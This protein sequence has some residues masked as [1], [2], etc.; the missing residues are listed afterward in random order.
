MREIMKK[1]RK[2]L[3]KIEKR[4]DSSTK[5]HG[6]LNTSSVWDCRGGQSC[7]IIS[8]RFENKKAKFSLER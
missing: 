3:A 8:S 1:E 4:Y 7:N 5:E 6:N 2:P